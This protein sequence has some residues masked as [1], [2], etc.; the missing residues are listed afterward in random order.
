MKYTEN[1]KAFRE[2]HLLLFNPKYILGRTIKIEEVDPNTGEAIKEPIIAF[3]EDAS[4]FEIDCVFRQDEHTSSEESEGGT[5]RIK[6][7][8]IKAQDIFHP[9][10]LRDLE[11]LEEDSTEEDYSRVYYRIEI[12][13]LK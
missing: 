4:K 11:D 7:M 1:K 13:D 9:Y 3:V 8:F 5:V 2:R 12:L 6:Q 10:N